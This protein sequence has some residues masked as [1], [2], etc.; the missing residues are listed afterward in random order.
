MEKVIARVLISLGALALIAGLSLLLAWP[1]MW[2][3]NYAVVSIWGFQ[4][5]HGEKHGV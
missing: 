5:L 4:L 1:I 2:C 3:W